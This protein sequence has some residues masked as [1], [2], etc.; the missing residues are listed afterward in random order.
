MKTLKLITTIALTATLGFSSCQSDDNTEVGTNPNANSSTSTTASNYERAAMNDGSNDDFLDGN[1]CTELLFPLTATVNDQQITLLSSLDFSAVLNILGEFNDDSDSVTFNFPIK[2]R[3]SNYTEVTVNN[4]SELDALNAECENA[5][6][7]GRDAISCI[8]I[9]FPVTMLTYDISLEQT[10]SVVLQSEQQLYSYMTS[11]GSDELFAVNYPIRTTL[12]NGTEIQIT[13]DAEFQNAIS[14]CVQYED[15]KDDAANTA[16]EAEAVLSGTKFKV[17]TF[18]NNGVDT[19]NDY[20]EWSIEFTNDFKIVATNF[21]NSALG[22]IEG[23]YS[24]S[25]ET[26]AFVNINFASNTALSALGNNWVISTYS[27]TLI[28]LQSTTDASVTLA[29]KKL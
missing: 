8:D 26:E 12:S 4:Q 27:T 29:F 6:E 23:T 16:A 5:E 13:S 22:E 3:S 7:E 15:E 19:A 24:V 1:A 25:S 18:I 14:D 17:E 21:V 11:L 2:V 28:T 9:N 10:G 20:A